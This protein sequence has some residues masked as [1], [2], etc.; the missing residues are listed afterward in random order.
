MFIYTNFTTSTTQQSLQN[1]YGLVI[2]IAIFSFI[3]FRRL[4]RYLRGTVLKPSSVILRT[5]I[6]GLITVFSFFLPSLGGIYI[7]VE[8]LV[9]P[10]GALMG[11]LLGDATLVYIL[12][13]KMMYK[14][15]ILITAFWVISYVTRIF[16]ELEFPLNMLLSTLSNIVLT[17]TFGL[18]VGES[19]QIFRKRTDI[20]NEAAQNMGL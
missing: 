4:S 9:F 1:L 12:D 2:F 15:S 18:I 11:F 17:F 6:Y 14:R 19:F 20:M 3:I 8:V 7:V 5:L 13:N 16:I 10:V